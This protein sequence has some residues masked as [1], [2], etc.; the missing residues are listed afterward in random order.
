LNRYRKLMD[1]FVLQYQQS[2]RGDSSHADKP[3]NPDPSLLDAHGASSPLPPEPQR[4][5]HQ[6]DLEM[7]VGSY[8]RDPEDS[9]HDPGD[10]FEDDLT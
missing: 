2:Q 7:F 5:K 4:V 8:P 1:D 3:D 10:D 9:D 6:E